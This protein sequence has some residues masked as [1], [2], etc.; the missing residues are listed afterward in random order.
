MPRY[1]VTCDSKPTNLLIGVEVRKPSK[2]IIR[3]FNPN[4]PNTYYLD[5]WQTVQKHGEFEA[6]MPQ[7]CDK[8]IVEIRSVNSNDDNIRITKLQKTDL[9][10]YA[11]CI[12]G[13]AKSFIKFAQEFCENASILQTGQ[14]YFSND[15]KFQIDYFDII[16]DG[17]RAIPTPA[18]ISNKNGRIEISKKHFAGYSV[19]MR[20]AILCHEY[21]HYYENVVTEDETEAD[22]NALKIYL[23]LGYPVI[24]AHKSF[25]NVFKNT[26]TKQNHE[27]YEYLKAFIDNFEDIKYRLCLP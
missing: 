25:L 16:R 9:V 27:R 10:Q 24:E 23:G 7:T 21:S 22:L 2:V 5:R 26:P 15:G 20:M 11:P 14:S 18:R 8:V 12:S 13:K 3:I 1:E 19:P 4:K 6:R 17:N